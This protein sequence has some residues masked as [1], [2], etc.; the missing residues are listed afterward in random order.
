MWVSGRA[1]ASDRVWPVKVAASGNPAT[2]RLQNNG[3][4]PGV[5]LNYY[6]NPLG[7]ISPSLSGT[8]AASR[9]YQLHHANPLTW[10]PSSRLSRALPAFLKLYAH[11]YC[12]EVDTTPS[13]LTLSGEAR[14]RQQCGT[15][16]GPTD[17]KSLLRESVGRF[18]YRSAYT[19]YLHPLYANLILAP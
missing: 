2:G 19:S 8:T 10:P 18:L 4:L 3:K 6:Y 14:G 1:A 11:S 9:R 5:F 13:H 17:V 12:R 16:G 15:A 7:L